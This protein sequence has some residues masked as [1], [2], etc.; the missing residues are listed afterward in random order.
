MAEGPDAISGYKALDTTR[1]YSFHHCP[2]ILYN[3]VAAGLDFAAGS[4]EWQGAALTSR[5]TH[6]LMQGQV[7]KRK[8]VRASAKAIRISITTYSAT[9][10]VCAQAG[11]WR[12]ADQLLV[13]ASAAALEVNVIACSAAMSASGKALLWKSAVGRLM[14]MPSLSLQVNIVGAGTTASAAGKRSEWK[15]A[16]LLMHLCAAREVEPNSAA[17]NTLTTAPWSGGIA[18]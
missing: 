3:Q 7:V 6:G 10:S 15:V 16:M 4:Q 1:C 14:Q 8:G 12:S 13:D 5:H 2:E 18:S 9:I 17:L 11:Q